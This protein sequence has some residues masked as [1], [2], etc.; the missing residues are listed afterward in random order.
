M[1]I[2]IHSWVGSE[3]KHIQAITLGLPWSAKDFHGFVVHHDRLLK[4]TLIDTSILQTS[5]EL[6]IMTYDFLTHH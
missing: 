6:T 4:P 2:Y 3:S 5:E 1:Y